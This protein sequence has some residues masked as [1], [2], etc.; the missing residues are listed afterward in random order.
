MRSA[1][2]SILQTVTNSL[3]KKSELLVTLLYR[4]QK[5]GDIVQGLPRIE[6]LLEARRPRDSAILCKKSGTVDIKK[7]DD[8]FPCP[9]CGI[10][11]YYDYNDKD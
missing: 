9:D 8:L 5:T 3:I 1:K 11:L 6:E 2:G 10:Y 4:K 7:G